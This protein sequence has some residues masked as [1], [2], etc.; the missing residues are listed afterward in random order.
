MEMRTPEQILR[1]A[2]E[3]SAYHG[4][5]HH[6]TTFDVHEYSRKEL[7]LEFLDIRDMIHDDGEVE[8]FNIYEMWGWMDYGA[9]LAMGVVP[10]LICI[11]DVEYDSPLGPA[12]EEFWFAL[13]SEDYGSSLVEDTVK[14]VNSSV[15][16][17]KWKVVV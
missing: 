7:Q 8:L 17:F 5:K 12:P 1:L 10:V 9:A 13:D 4:T 16:N 2:N 6:F 15:T 3:L 14:V 11:Y